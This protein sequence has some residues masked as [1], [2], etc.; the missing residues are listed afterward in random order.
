MYN[1][2][3]WNQ[4]LLYFFCNALS[5]P[6]CARSPVYLIPKKKT[7]S[8]WS[9]IKMLPLSNDL[10]FY[11]TS[12]APHSPN[13]LT[14]TLQDPINFSSNILYNLEIHCIMKVKCEWHFILTYSSEAIVGRFQNCKNQHKSHYHCTHE[15]DT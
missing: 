14:S 5:W 2:E 7:Y 8:A 4:N 11:M 13:F 6:Y 9:V 15:Q 1:Y 3:W 10:P 12:Q